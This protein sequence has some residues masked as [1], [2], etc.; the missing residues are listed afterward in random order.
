MVIL[1]NI[2]LKDMIEIWK[3]IKDYE[4]LYQV[5]NLGRVKSLITNKILKS[6]TVNGGYRFVRLYKDGVSKY[7]LVHRLVA[8]AF[9]YNPDPIKNNE[10]EHL[11]TIRDDN[12]AVNLEWVDHIKNCNNPL[13]KK[14][15]SG[16]FGKEHNRSIPINQLN[17]IGEFIKEWECAIQVE[18]ELGI[19]HS[20]ISLCCNGKRKSA[21]GYVWKYKN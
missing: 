2:K 20:N 18:R 7:Y 8:Q 12:R 21:G 19:N 10:V 13:T 17:L 16:K 3:D 14:H 6:G 11:N 5:S 4:G 15:L 9:V 1:L